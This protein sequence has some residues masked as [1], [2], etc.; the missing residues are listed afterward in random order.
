MGG[1]F[2]GGGGSKSPP[3]SGGTFIKPPMSEATPEPLAPE[4]L[5]R[6]KTATPLKKEKAA[7]GNLSPSAED[8]SLGD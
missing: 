1:L 4:Y 7:L 5:W 6:S 8:G 3:K 2:G